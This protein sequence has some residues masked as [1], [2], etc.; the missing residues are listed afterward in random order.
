MCKPAEEVEGILGKYLPAAIRLEDVQRV[1]GLFLH[2][3]GLDGALAGSQR[4]SCARTIGKRGW[5][6]PCPWWFGFW[7]E[8]KEW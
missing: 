7:A 3:D 6:S 4:R 8:R 2:F 1:H 5:V